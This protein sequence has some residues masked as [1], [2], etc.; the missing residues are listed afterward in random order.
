MSTETGRI[1]ESANINGSLV[2]PV[3]PAGKDTPLLVVG[4]SFDTPSALVGGWT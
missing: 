4:G 3:L 2:R 1:V